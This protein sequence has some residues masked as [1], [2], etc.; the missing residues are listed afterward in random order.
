MPQYAHSK[1]KICNHKNVWLFIEAC[2]RKLSAFFHSLICH[3]LQC[4]LNVV[5]ILSHMFTVYRFYPHHI[6]AH[7]NHSSPPRCPFWCGQGSTRKLGKKKTPDHNLKLALKLSPRKGKFSHI[8]LHVR[9]FCNCKNTNTKKSKQEHSQVYT[10]YYVSL[11]SAHV[12]YNNPTH[13]IVPPSSLCCLCLTHTHQT[14]TG[15]LGWPIMSIGPSLIYLVCSG[16]CACQHGVCM[17]SWSSH[18]SRQG[19]DV[20]NSGEDRK[21]ERGGPPQRSSIFHRLLN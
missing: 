4:H 1:W 20:G 15:R 21:S 18:S 13:S 19:E 2:Y 11:L 17:Q 3:P 8:S 5:R 9:I 10:Y 14:H 6:L 16:A 7:Y 12:L